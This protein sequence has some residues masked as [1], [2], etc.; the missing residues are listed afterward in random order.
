LTRR[1]PA[2]IIPA[3]EYEAQLSFVMNKKILAKKI[4][5]KRNPATFARWARMWL[6]LALCLSPAFAQSAS[7]GNAQNTSATAPAK[8]SPAPS[9]GTSASTKPSDAE[10]AAAK[11]QGKVWVNLDTKIYH[12]SGRWY[13]KT[14]NGQFM[15]EA[16]AKAAG[17]KASH[18]N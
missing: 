6:A 1:P 12:K 9:A 11:A 4:S 8:K 5:L 18:S 2:G 14:K 15:T 10:I 3:K 13:G 16:E 7:P 17:Y